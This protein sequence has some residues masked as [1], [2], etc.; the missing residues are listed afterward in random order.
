VEV[1][2]IEYNIRNKFKDFEMNIAFDK[3]SKRMGILG[4]SGSGKSM[5]LKYLAGIVTPHSGRI[6]LNHRVLFDS[7]KNINVLPRNRKV[8][9]LFQNYALFPHLTVEQ[10]IAIG[11]ANRN[12]KRDIVANQMEQF[13]LSG[14]EKR[15][16]SQISGG[17]QQRVALARIMANEP[18]AILLDEPFSALD[19]YLKDTLYEQLQELLKN[20]AGDVVIVSHNLDEIYQFCEKLVVIE[21]GVSIMSEDTQTVFLQPRRLET[22]KLTGCKNISPIKRVDSHRLEALSWGVH[23]DT[24]Q[25]ISDDIT[26][27][28][29]RALHL[30]P[31]YEKKSINCMAVQLKAVTESLFQKRFTMCPVQDEKVV[32]ESQIRWYV[33]KEEFHHKH[34]EQIPPFIYLPPERLML[35]AT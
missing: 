19:S 28:G 16:P 30:M 12:Q 10:N 3:D 35:L 26:H 22:A 11:I 23:L 34:K 18:E 31:A 27:V 7:K 32:E 24:N 15:Y 8:G 20:Y 4:A 2:A 29:I 33:C 6:V 9:Y 25:T 13:H 17:Q 1:M 21:N 5:A 14:L